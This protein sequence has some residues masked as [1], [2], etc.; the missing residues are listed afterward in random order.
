MEIYEYL[1]VSSSGEI[2]SAGVVSPTND[3]FIF[4][5]PASMQF[6]PFFDRVSLYAASNSPSDNGAFTVTYQENAVGS[7]Q[8][9]V[10]TTSPTQNNLTFSNIDNFFFSNGATYF[11][12]NI[13]V[14]VYGS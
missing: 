14:N 13:V 4:G 11:V 6:S 8:T 3:L 2:L 7:V 10:S 5:T 1:C 9:P 12:D